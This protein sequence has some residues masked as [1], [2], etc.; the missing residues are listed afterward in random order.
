MSD[1]V[2]K[3]A[4]GQVAGGGETIEDLLKRQQVGFARV[5][6]GSMSPERFA[7]LVLTECRKNPGLLRCSPVSLLGAAMTAA[8]LGLEPGPLQHCYLVPRKGEVTFQLGYRGMIEL[9]L[10]GGG[11]RSIDAHVVGANDEFEYAYGTDAYLH[12]VPNLDDPG[13]DRCVY[14]V[15][16]LRDGGTPFV[17]LSIAE[18]ER[19]RNRSSA[20]DSPAWTNDRPAMMRKTAIRALEPYLPKSAELA[21]A[22]NLDERVR[23]DWTVPID[24]T[25]GDADLPLPS[26]EGDPAGGDPAGSL[27]GAGSDVSVTPNVTASEPPAP[28]EEAEVV[29]LE[30]A[31]D[32]L[33][34]LSERPLSEWPVA[35]MQEELRSRRLPVKGTRD[36]ILDRLRSHAATPTGA[37]PAWAPEPA[38]A[39]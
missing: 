11:M 38:E 20:P 13:P 14:A 24:Q 10:R 25:D 21:L 16:Q 26:P 37:P 29:P 22:L 2:A 6:P 39:E 23:T 8:Q 15:A 35:A 19:R 18:V 27:A 30:A 28:V 17:V 12:H 34:A 36:E 7:R 4:G 1:L 9:A 5:L 33:P 31:P 3:M 32:P